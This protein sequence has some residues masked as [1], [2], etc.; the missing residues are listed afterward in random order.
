MR[1]LLGGKGAGLA[2]MM[3]AGV[4]VP[5]GFTIT[6]EA[7]RCYFEAG[8][9]SRERRRARRRRCSRASSG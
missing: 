4:P 5:P 8:G 7:C 1:D 6:T 9:G 2:E 3:N